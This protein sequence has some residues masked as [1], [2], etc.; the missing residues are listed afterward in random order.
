MINTVLVQK[1]VGEALDKRT[2]RFE[3]RDGIERFYPALVLISN[4]LISDVI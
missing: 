4:V 2:I 3:D 1:P